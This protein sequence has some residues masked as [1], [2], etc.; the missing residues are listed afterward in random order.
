MLEKALKLLVRV[1]RARVPRMTLLSN[2]SCTPQEKSLLAYK[3]V[4][5]RLLRASV[6]RL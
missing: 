3:K 1:L 2:T 6:S 5:Y 4:R